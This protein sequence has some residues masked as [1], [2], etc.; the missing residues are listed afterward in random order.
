MGTSLND[1]IALTKENGLSKSSHFTCDFTIPPCMQNA[2]SRG[3]VI[4][5][6]LLCKTNQ[7]PGIELLSM[8]HEE[9]G[10]NREM[11]YQR[12]YG[13]IT[14]TYILDIDLQL[15]RFFEDWT[16]CIIDP[17]TRT[18]GYYNDYITD[19][20][21]ALEDSSPESKIRYKVKLFE[22]YPKS[23]EPIALDYSATGFTELSVNLNYKYYRI[24]GN[25]D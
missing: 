17:V 6:T 15:R 13:N 19:I 11:P 23:V 24:I 12:T 7:L 4:D 25:E 10:E 14:L 3:A 21:I 16:N 2:D 9:F 8:N 18:F 22:C 5:F 1:F 20:V